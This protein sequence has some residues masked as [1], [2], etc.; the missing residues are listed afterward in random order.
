MLLPNLTWITLTPCRYFY[1]PHEIE[2]LNKDPEYHLNYRKKI[3]YGMNAGFRIFYKGSDD[4]LMAQKY[5]AAEMARRLNYHPELTK[6]L[7]PDW[8]VGCR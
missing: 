4:S 3:E 1:K 8:P 2:K 5:M 7:V 6:R